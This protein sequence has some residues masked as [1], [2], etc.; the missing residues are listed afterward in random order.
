MGSRKLIVEIIG[1]SSSLEKSFLRSGKAAQGFTAQI[2]STSKAV[3]NAFAAVG[4]T[5]GVAAGVDQIRKTVAAA[6]DLEEQLNKSNVVFGRSAANIQ[7]WSETTAQAFGLSQ[8]AALE[9]AA[10]FGQIL[11]TSGLNQTESARFSRSL[12]ELASDLASFNNLETTDALDKLRSGLVGEAEPLR[13]I[14]VLLSEARVQQEAYASGIA[15]SGAKLTEGQKVQARYALILRDTAS[16]QGDFGRTSESLANQQRILAAQV[17]NL[18]G[19]IGQAFLPAV[20]EAI[21]GLNRWLASSENQERVQKAVGRTTTIAGSAL[22]GFAQVVKGLAPVV[23]SLVRNLGGAE[24]AVK[25]LAAAFIATKAARFVGVLD[26]VSASAVTATGK[27]NLLRT[28]LL[29]LG[30]IGVITLAVAVVINREQ[31]DNTVNDFLRGKGLGFLTAPVIDIPV[32][33][34]VT[35]LQAVRDRLAELKGEG[36]FVV[37]ALDEVILKLRRMNEE[38]TAGLRVAGKLGDERIGKPERE[39]TTKPPPIKLPAGVQAFL[40]ALERMRAAAQGRIADMLSLAQRAQALKKAADEAAFAVER[41]SLV[42]QAASATPTLRDDIVA[43]KQIGAAL[44]AQEDAIA[45]RLALNRNDLGLQRE[46]LSVQSQQLANEQALAAAIKERAKNQKAAAAAAVQA[47]QFRA[48]GRSS[49]GDELTPTVKALRSQ[50]AKLKDLIPGSAL[51]TAKISSLLDRVAKLFAGKFGKITEETRKLL[52]SIF[53]DLN[54]QL[55][56]SGGPLT[57][58]SGL[59]T[60]KILEGLGLDDAAAAELR[61]RLSG[62]NTAGRALASASTL[63]PQLGGGVIAGVPINLTTTVVLDG[64]VVGKSVTRYQQKAGRRNP[65]QKRGPNR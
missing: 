65:K 17:E 44:Q 6:S 62:F 11:E 59:N 48:L 41:L 63:T 30:A 57:K 39:F 25:L 23:A 14:G 64:E 18:R 8:R 50:F 43:Y 60:K 7:A 19:K 55:K 37:K 27:V 36:F 29:R 32:D 21:Q 2:T 5:V 22:S 1:D 56:Q 52:A 3:R 49:T 9:A 4:V 45:A 13:R 33:A 58:T 26:A 35:K 10:G 12:V 40:A 42:L 34:D 54:N 28:A 15:E 31:L 46:L 61:S 53:D 51:D 20:T 47:A 24:K 16:A 38:A